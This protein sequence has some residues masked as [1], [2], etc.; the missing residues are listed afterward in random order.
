MTRRVAI[1]TGA[2]S[3]IS[4]SIAKHLLEE[5][6]RVVGLDIQPPSP[7]DTARFRPFLRCER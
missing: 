3:G 6:L 2:A 5:G 7:F 1:V 4:R